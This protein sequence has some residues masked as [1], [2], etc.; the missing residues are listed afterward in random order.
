MK[1]I[2]KGTVKNIEKVSIDVFKIEIKSSVKNANAGQFISILC[3]PVTL[4]RPFS[5][6]GFDNGTI[7]VLFKEKGEGTKYI[8]SLKI[9]DEVDFLG[10]LGNG[11]KIENKKAL[12]VGAGIGIA[13]M[14]FLSDELK[15]KN[16]E[17]YLVCGFKAKEEIIAGADEVTIGGSVLDNLQELINFHKPEI[18]YSCGPHIVLENVAKIAQKNNLKSQV[19]M[20]K[21]MACSIGVCRGCVIQIKKDGEI[22]NATICHDGPVFEGDEPVW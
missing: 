12:L 19:A 3:P 16:I 22:Q 17:N 10:P 11:F 13:P 18:L 14:L 4:R 2:Q 1:K 9:G 7:T 8:K 6:C 20:E 15:K 5:I 21:V